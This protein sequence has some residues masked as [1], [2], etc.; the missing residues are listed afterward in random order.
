MSLM[1]HHLYL[2]KVDFLSSD[3][4]S[5]PLNTDLLGVAPFLVAST[6]QLPLVPC[7]P[8]PS[9]PE[10]LR[11]H[12]APGHSVTWRKYGWPRLTLSGGQFLRAGL[13]GRPSC[14]LR[15]G[16]S[17]EYQPSGAL[18]EVIPAVDGRALAASADITLRSTHTDL[19]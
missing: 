2:L 13:A 14:D 8:W 9:G 16:D 4:V 17:F 18:G 10:S 7:G 5:P 12:R 11:P 6:F 1:G 3:F 19:V 15:D